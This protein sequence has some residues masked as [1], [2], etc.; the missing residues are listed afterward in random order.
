MPRSFSFSGTRSIGL[1]G[2][3][4]PP[5]L[6]PARTRRRLGARLQP[7]FRD[8]KNTRLSTRRASS[9]K[10]APAIVQG[11]RSPGSRPRLPRVPCR[12]TELRGRPGP[13][14]A[15]S[16]RERPAGRPARGNARGC[17]GRAGGRMQGR[18]IEAAPRRPRGWSGCLNRPPGRRRRWRSC[19]VAAAIKRWRWCKTSPARS[20]PIPRS[21]SGWCKAGSG[22][23][24]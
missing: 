15:R 21:G 6:L 7:R 13:S 16:R 5:W 17:P 2:G 8:Q 1:A 14:P 9:W 11:N 20:H 22:P 18:S 10:R 24:G 3:R 23:A 12:S 4:V 19:W